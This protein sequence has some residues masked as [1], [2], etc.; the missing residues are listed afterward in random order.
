[1]RDGR[2]VLCLKEDLKRKQGEVTVPLCLS[3]QKQTL[4]ITYVIIVLFIILSLKCVFY[5][6]DQGISS[7]FII[8]WMLSG[9]VIFRAYSFRYFDRYRMEHNVRLSGNEMRR[10]VLEE[11]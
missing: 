6:Y 3:F 11:K 10:L 7:R 1:M 4:A 9:R 2:E 8:I 5:L